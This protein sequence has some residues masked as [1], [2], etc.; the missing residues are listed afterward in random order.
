MPKKNRKRSISDLSLVEMKDEAIQAFL[1]ENFSRKS[2]DATEGSKES[3]NS[4]EEKEK[5]D[6]FSDDNGKSND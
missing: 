4:I 2:S 6:C 1:D 5:C 3:E